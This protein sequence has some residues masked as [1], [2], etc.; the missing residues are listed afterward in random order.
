ML[1]QQLRRGFSRTIPRPVNAAQN[2]CLFCC[3]M[4]RCTER[5]NTVHQQRGYAVRAPRRAPR[6]IPVRRGAL[7]EDDAPPKDVATLLLEAVDF[8]VIGNSIKERIRPLLQAFTNVTQPEANK[9]IVAAADF[10]QISQHEIYSV[11]RCLCFPHQPPL[12][13][14]V[15]KKLLLALAANGNQQAV[16]YLLHRANQQGHGID[17]R[18]MHSMELAPVMKQLALLA[19]G[20][21]PQAMMLSAELTHSRG[22]LDHAI[23]LVRE[24]L[25]LELP[26]APEPEPR[27][28]FGKKKKSLSDQWLEASET[29]HKTSAW[30]ALGRYLQEKGDRA[31]AI[32]A[33]EKATQ[34]NEEP[35][36]NA[37][38][39]ALEAAS[40]RKWSLKWFEHTLQAARA[41]GVTEIF[42]LGELYG[43][44][45]DKISNREVRRK[46]EQL[47]ADDFKPKFQIFNLT[48]SQRGGI[49]FGETPPPNVP[50]YALLDQARTV[51]NPP[52]EKIIE[53]QASSRV[54]KALEWLNVVYGIHE[55][56]PYK[57][58]QLIKTYFDPGAKKSK[59]PQGVESWTGRT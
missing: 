10:N 19:K 45:L 59:K 30:M 37:N 16:V 57:L 50:L 40:G 20:K 6:K 11:G 15:G 51:G 26:E 7:L 47:E 52:K 22:Q 8:S 55:E 41:G 56:A 31:G 39:A 38:L 5:A 46:M 49:L 58:T 27:S 1:R 44:P 34:G 21:D 18:L 28:I 53:I 54:G 33:Y 23:K 14:Q 12:A 24:V 4:R 32:E 42:N 3:L 2:D 36:A 35:E 13:R 17:A 9:N 29:F 25:E 48:T 43:A